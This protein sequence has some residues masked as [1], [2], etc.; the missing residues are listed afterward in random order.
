MKSFF[1]Y[2]KNVRAELE[3]V[4]WPKPKTSVGHTILIVLLSAFTAVLLGILDHL[5]TSGVGQ[6]IR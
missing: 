2:L 4:V 5:F 1:S 3:H 6:I